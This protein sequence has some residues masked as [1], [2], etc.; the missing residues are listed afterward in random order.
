MA[1]KKWSIFTRDCAP[2]DEWNLYGAQP[3]YMNLEEDGSANGVFLLNS[4]A[5]E[6]IMQPDPYPA[7]SYQV[8]GGVLDFYIFLGP[9]PENIVQQYT[10]AVGRPVMV[11][12]WGLGFQLSRWDYDNLTHVREVVDRNRAAGIPQD[13]QYGDIDYMHLKHGFTYDKVK[14]EGLPEFVDELHARG[15]KYI[16]ILDNFIGANETLFQLEF[17]GTYKPYTDGLNDG[18]FIMDPRDETKPLLGEVWPGLSV[19]PDFTML[20]KSK[21]WWRTQS[22]DFYNNWDVQFDALWIDMNE[23]S[24]FLQGS[25]TGC[26]ENLLN[27]PPYVPNVLGS[28]DENKPGMLYDKTICMDAPQEW[29]LHYDVHSLYGHSHSIVTY[30]TLR[31]MFPQKRPFAL[32]RSNFAG[33]GKYATHWLGDNQSLWEHLGWSIIG[34]LLFHKLICLIHK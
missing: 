15:Q 32:T 4:N 17:N 28:D 31:D 7:I 8:I 26:D 34:M 1:W 12:Y 2:V 33:T 14:Y 13:V 5:M 9:T 21:D 22:E 25:T 23:P 27:F 24:N 19:Y 30:N 3:F 20:D 6:V 18:I 16:I 10:E 29:G 11:P